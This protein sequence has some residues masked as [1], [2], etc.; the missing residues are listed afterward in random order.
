MRGSSVLFPLAVSLCLCFTFE[1]VDGRRVIRAAPNAEKTGYYIIK[2]NQSLTHDEFIRAEE[3]ILKDSEDV[4]VYEAENDMIKVVTVKVNETNLEKVC[5]IQG[6]G[7][8][9][10]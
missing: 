1:P 4:P 3:E 9:S 5:I 10:V 8:G 7:W 6:W 2:L